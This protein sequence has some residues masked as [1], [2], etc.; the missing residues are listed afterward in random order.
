MIIKLNAA[1]ITFKTGKNTIAKEKLSN[2]YDVNFLK[3]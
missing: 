1:A 3:N 2:H